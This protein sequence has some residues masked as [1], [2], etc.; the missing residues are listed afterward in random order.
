MVFCCSAAAIITAALLL[1]LSPAE[2]QA[3][4]GDNGFADVLPL[5]AH[6]PGEPLGTAAALLGLM[7]MWR[8]F[9]AVYLDSW[10]WASARWVGRKGGGD[11]QRRQQPF[12]LCRT[13]VESSNQGYICSYAASSNVGIVKH[14][15]LLGLLHDL[16][17]HIH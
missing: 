8:S 7:A 3:L 16:L 10:V 1:P 9:Y 6:G 13:G 14:C 15:L 5:A 11:G 17:L 4:V 2:S 12:L